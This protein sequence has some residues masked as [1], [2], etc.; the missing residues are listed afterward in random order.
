MPFSLLICDCDGV[1][2]DSEVL[3]C[4]VDA[5]ELAQ[6][7]FKDY[8]LETVLGRFAGVS[9]TDFIRLVEAEAG[10]PIGA[11]F[12][13]AVAARVE[14][15][16]RTELKPLPQVGAVLDSLDLLKC[17]AS[18]SMPPKLDL[19]LTVTG[20]KAHFAPHIFSSVSVT[21][22]KPA[23]DLFL[24]AAKAL[25]VPPEGCCVIEDSVAGVTA[26]HAAGMVAIGFTGGS[27]CSSDQAE[28]LRKHGA[29]AIVDDWGK[30]PALL[31][32]LNS[33]PID[34]KQTV[35]WAR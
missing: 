7:G 31:A 24:H 21:R 18:S 29:A 27:H 19:A 28:R 1:L 11:D 10:R 20:L 35:A 34:N 12:A 30:V 17:V 13:I 9:Q 2:V 22:G 26:A 25:G 32:R 5:E 3:A 16:L 8:P 15:V 4:R 33:G 23:P 14:E 6:R